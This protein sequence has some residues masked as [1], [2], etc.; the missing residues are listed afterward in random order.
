MKFRS[1]SRFVSDFATLPSSH[2]KMFRAR[3]KEFSA[4]CD[5]W[6][7]SGATSDAWPGNLRVYRLSNS[8][9]WSL[10]WHYRRP[11]ARAVF[12]FF[13]EN[14]ETKVRWLRIGG[15]EIYEEV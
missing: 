7:K 11:D 14:G 4:G 9:L 13:E 2:Q 6:A 15:H 3:M 12:E 10:T 8:S 1:N 5:Q